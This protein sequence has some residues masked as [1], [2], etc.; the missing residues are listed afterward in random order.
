M[1]SCRDAT[2]SGWNVRETRSRS[3]IRWTVNVWWR[4]PR[5]IRSFE[6]AQRYSI[7]HLAKLLRD[8]QWKNPAA[9]AGDLRRIGSLAATSDPASLDAFET[10]AIPHRVQGDSTD[11]RSQG[12]IF[13]G[14]DHF[15]VSAR[16]HFECRQSARSYVLS[17]S[18]VLVAVSCRCI[19]S[20]MH[21]AHSRYDNVTC[22][23]LETLCSLLRDGTG[24]P[25]LLDGNK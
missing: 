10:F 6:H 4:R 5:T 17:V 11:D 2:V 3:K 15:V 23:R 24:A 20:G 8:G 21:A 7:H 9:P 12:F 16:L 18:R 25:A 19:S 1:T 14:S 13:A 22:G